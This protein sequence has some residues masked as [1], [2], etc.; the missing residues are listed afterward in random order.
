MAYIG[1]VDAP[2]FFTADACRAAGID[3]ATLKNWITRTPSAILLS[4]EDKLKFQEA[5]APIETE[6]RERMAAG[7]GRSH[8]FTF[9]RVMQIALTAELVALGFPPRKAGMVAVGFT[10]VGHG[11]AGYV[12]D[13]EPIRIKRLPG[14]LYPD[15]WTILV[16]E[17]DR[18]TGRTVNVHHNTLL[19]ELLFTSAR[20][21]ST[22]V[23]VNVNA[24]DRRVRAALGLDMNWG[25]RP[26]P[27]DS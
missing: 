18:E 5:G 14:E 3:P 20:P 27:K 15:G 23:I 16:A 10:D 13:G 2:Q 19:T 12:G 11:G 17:S 4:Q 24:V 21:P 7:S 22:L 6:P 26:R 8:L 1:D 9:R 25:R